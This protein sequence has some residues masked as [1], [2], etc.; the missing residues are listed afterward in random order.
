MTM[1]YRIVNPER[2]GF[3]HNDAAPKLSIER[4]SI[5]VDVARDAYVRT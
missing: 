2:A 3:V 4:M 5:I 1:W